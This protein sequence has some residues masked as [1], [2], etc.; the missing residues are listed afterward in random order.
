MRNINATKIANSRISV[1]I[2]KAYFE[3]YLAS[4]FIEYKHLSL[5]K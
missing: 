3:Y 1:I 2:Y 4:N 5:Y